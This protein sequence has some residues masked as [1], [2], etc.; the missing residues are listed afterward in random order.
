LLDT[1]ACLPPRCSGWKKCPT[2]RLE[3]LTESQIRAYVLADN[4]LALNAG[5]DKLILAIEFEHLLAINEEIDIT[6]T[7]FEMP[8]IDLILQEA[9]QAADR[10]MNFQLRQTYQLSPSPETYG[11][12]GNIECSAVILYRKVAIKH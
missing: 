10:R 6:V 9:S 11:S 4:Q 1:V 3:T 5:W 8:E 12:S 7:G 2:I